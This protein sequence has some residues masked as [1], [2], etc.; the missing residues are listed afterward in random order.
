MAL[1]S[2]VEGAARAVVTAWWGECG[3]AGRDAMTPGVVVVGWNGGLVSSTK[4]R[5]SLSRFLSDKWGMLGRV[6]QRVFAVKGKDGERYSIV[7][8]RCCLSFVDTT[9]CIYRRAGQN[10][11]GF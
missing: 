7:A 8:E 3:T 6:G 11:E 2:R 9:L 5:Q 4:V 1:P 10:E